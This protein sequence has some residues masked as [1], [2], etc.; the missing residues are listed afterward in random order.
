[1]SEPGRDL[2]R[3]AGLAALIGGC[4]LGLYVLAFKAGISLDIVAAGLPDVWWRI[5][6]LLLSAL[7]DGILEDGAG[8]RLPTEQAPAAQRQPQSGLSRSP[9]SYAA[10][11]TCTKGLVR[12]SATPI[13]GV[14]FGVLFLRLAA[15]EPDDHRAL[16]DQLGGVP[17]ATRCS[18]DMCRGYRDSARRAECAEDSGTAPR[19]SLSGGRLSVTDPQAACNQGM[20]YSRERWSVYDLIPDPA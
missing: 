6:V 3:G 8:R 15:D 19:N 9:P 10:P 4:G 17:S 14:I 12:S 11:I 2:L 16:A 7:Q 1:V 20:P 18:R 13:M 5:P